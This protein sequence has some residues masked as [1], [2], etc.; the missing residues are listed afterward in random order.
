[1]AL[2]ALHQLRVQAQDQSIVVAKNLVSSVEQ[3]IDGLIRSADNSLLSVSDEL[4]RQMT[5]GQVN[6][7]SISDYVNRQVAR[8]PH[9]S[10]IKATNEHGDV[11]YGHDIH[12][13]PL[14]NADRDHFISLRSDNALGLF[15]SKAILSRTEKEWVWPFARRVNN[16]DNS[17]AGIVFGGIKVHNIEKMLNQIQIG[18]GNII[19]IRDA[20]LGLIARHSDDGNRAVQ[21]GDKR[22]SEAFRQALEVNNLM[23]AYVG[24]TGSIDG[25]NRVF[26][27]S[28]SPHYGF[29]TIVGTSLESALA[30]WE[31]AVWVVVSFLLGITLLTLVFAWSLSRSVSRQDIH[32][33]EMASEKLQSYTLEFYDTLTGL[34]NRGL[35]MNRLSQALSTCE[36][37]GQLGALFLIDLDNFKIL[38]DSMGHS[39]G[40]L[41]LKQVG[42]R[43]GRC[44][45]GNGIVAH[46]GGD[47]FV[48]ILEALADNTSDAKILAES[49]GN[50]I[51]SALN[52]A[53]LLGNH[54]YIGS[55]SIGITIF[56]NAHCSSDTLLKQADIAMYQAKQA[57]R[58]CLRFLDPI[59]Q[60]GIAKRA[61]LE[62]EL[63]LALEKQQFELYF[64]IQVNREGNHS[65]VEVL[66]RWIHPERGVIGPLEFISLAEENGLILPI[67]EWVLTSACIQIKKWA[68]LPILRDLIVSVNVSVKQ[69]IQP[70]FVQQ[71]KA[72]LERYPIP[73]NHLE[74]ELTE[75]VLLTDFHLALET[76]SALKAVGIRFSLDDFGTGYSSFQ[77]LKML[78]FNQ[79]KIDQSFVRELALD[80]RDNM[81]VSAIL[82]M[83]K[84]LDLDVIA[85]GV[86]TLQQQQ[87]LLDY[88]CSH[89]QGYLFGKPLPIKEFESLIGL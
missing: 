17:F 50:L 53:Y 55:A 14:N 84:A 75:D 73:D 27:F 87:I 45:K 2:Y 54:T 36:R 66:L 37:S 19:S 44:V 79:L 31:H 78:P 51:L 67:G 24:G 8:A 59:I 35:L 42:Q 13:P 77:Y 86:E 9:I 40:D 7:A 82:A 88:G 65:G 57:G 69:F 62:T 52:Q 46:V 29:T 85:E 41:L 80:N 61:F 3:T 38:N 70:H 76:M 12:Q 39:R 63:Y 71:I 56:K 33:S 58:N 6:V 49:I 72:I 47:E 18:K 20:D 4:S 15:V 25:L 34:P 43:I 22:I 23:G 5:E 64:Q 21:P 32:D 68:D 60:D 30:S 10:Y 11:I 16:S 81:L 48:V 1:M 74:I 28:R 26:F 83:A 89:L